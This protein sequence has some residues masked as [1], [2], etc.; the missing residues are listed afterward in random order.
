MFELTNILNSLKNKKSSPGP[1]GIP[2]SCLC[3]LSANGKQFLLDLAN[4]SWE[5]GEVSAKLKSSYISPI[6]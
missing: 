1:D 6:S 3:N 5:L 4:H 2:Y